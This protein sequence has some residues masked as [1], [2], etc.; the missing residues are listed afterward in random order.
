MELLS[1]AHGISD[2]DNS[3]THK[4]SVE[5]GYAYHYLLKGEIEKALSHSQEALKYLDAGCCGSTPLNVLFLHT[6]L[7]ET[8][9]WSY[10]INEAMSHFGKCL[11]HISTFPFSG[12]N[13]VS[14]LNNQTR[15]AAISLNMDNAQQ[16]ASVLG[17]LNRLLPLAREKGSKRNVAEMLALLALCTARTHG[18]KEESEALMTEAIAAAVEFGD[19]RTSAIVYRL[20]GIFYSRYTAESFVKGQELL[21]EA[22]AFAKTIGDQLT[23]ALILRDIA[24]NLVEAEPEETKENIWKEHTAKSLEI[25]QKTGNKYLEA[26][27]QRGAS[28]TG[29]HPDIAAAPAPAEH[30]PTF[31]EVVAAPAAEHLEKE[32]RESETPAQ[33]N[34]EESKPEVTP[35]H[36][37]EEVTP[38]AEPVH[39]HEEQAAAQEKES[40]P[41]REA[42][43]SVPAAEPAQAEEQTETPTE[44]ASRHEEEQ[45]QQQQHP[46]YAEVVV[47]AEESAPVQEEKDQS[48]QATAGEPAADVV[49]VETKQEEETTT[50]TTTAQEV[51]ETTV[52]QTEVKQEEQQQQQQQLKTE[53]EEVAVTEHHQVVVEKE[54]KEEEEVKQQQQQQQ[55][56]EEEEEEVKEEEKQEAGEESHS[57][58][59]HE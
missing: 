21:E 10:N 4:G 6:L 46:S 48:E 34:F 24:V 57:D 49:V 45:Q 43:P 19:K 28:T 30:K 41:S 20:A 39:V 31:A 32:E 44:T 22:L 58:E 38:A 8:N 15:L 18:P 56:E 52:E 36:S 37:V 50:T 26:I 33:P 47:A 17:M 11:E 1:L 42:E 51:V 13:V 9:F 29:A 25:A 12:E 14:L 5:V 53:N 7:A 54:E 16:D 2:K 40:E 59:H 3:L 55:Q 27:L 23:E 35:E